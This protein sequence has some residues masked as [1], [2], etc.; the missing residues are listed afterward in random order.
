MEIEDIQID[1]IKPDPN[2][3][4]K[5]FDP[6]TEQEL[7]KTMQQ[8]GIINP[9]E[10]DENNVIITGERRWRAIKLTNLTTIPCKRITGL[11][12]KERFIRQVT[13]NTSRKPLNYIEQREAL[14]TIK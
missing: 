12:P 7:A 5:Y 4:R 9:I 11:S 13:E 1:S 3:P 6:E 14:L 8:G 2:Q 10:I